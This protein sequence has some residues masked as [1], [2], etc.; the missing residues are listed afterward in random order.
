[1]SLRVFILVLIA[2]RPFATVFTVRCP[3]PVRHPVSGIS[4]ISL[5]HTLCIPLAL[6]QKSLHL[7]SPTFHC[8]GQGSIA[9]HESRRVSH[10]VSAGVVPHQE[11]WP[12]GKG[13]STGTLE[14]GLEGTSSYR[15]TS[16]SSC[17]PSSILRPCHPYHVP[18]D[19]RSGFG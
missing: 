7:P 13:T 3:C 15:T 8:S 18:Y 6:V 11:G 16:I 2:S 17:R 10:P 1:V 5:V 12:R 9:S 4:K 19:G 14:F